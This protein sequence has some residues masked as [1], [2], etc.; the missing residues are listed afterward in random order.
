MDLVN[1]PNNFLLTYYTKDYDEY[2]QFRFYHNESPEL[3]KIFDFFKWE[4]ATN[5][6]EY[7]NYV[8]PRIKSSS[9]TTHDKY[10][11]TMTFMYEKFKN[12]VKML[13][14]NYNSHLTDPLQLKELVSFVEKWRFDHLYL[15]D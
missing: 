2:F 7:V 11:K 8:M 9:N 1:H 12:M 6:N 5:G 10:I 13:F 3:L 14:S 15:R 4:L